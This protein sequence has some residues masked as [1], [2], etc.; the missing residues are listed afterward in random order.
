MDSD[1]PVYASRKRSLVRGV[2]NYNVQNL[3][4]PK[5]HLSI[6]SNHK[7]DFCF[8]KF[9]KAQKMIFFADLS[10]VVSGKTCLK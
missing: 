7:N 1:Y 3:I 9:F 10:I 6:G 8:L 2:I 5:N 4:W